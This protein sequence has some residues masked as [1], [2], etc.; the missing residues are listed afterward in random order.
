MKVG[1]RENLSVIL[2]ASLTLLGLIIEFDVSMA[3]SRCQP[4][5]NYGEAEAN[6]IGTEYLRA[7]LLPAADAA[8]VRSLL[9]KYLDERLL[10]YNA[11]DEQQ[12]RQIYANTAP[13]TERAV[14]RDPCH[15]RRTAD[16]R[17]C[18]GRFEHKRC[19]ELAGIHPGGLVEPNI[20]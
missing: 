10:F 11:R 19:V 13:I 1:V 16:V 12:L 15:G 5:K 6:A 8:R 14:G 20:P 18:L 17:R 3:I 9:R 4:R 2:A 7:D